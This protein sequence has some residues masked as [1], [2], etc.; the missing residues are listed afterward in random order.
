MVPGKFPDGWPADV[1][2]GD[3]DGEDDKE[4]EVEQEEHG[5]RYAQVG[6]DARPWKGEQELR[7]ARGMRLVRC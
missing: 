2:H 7:A 5:R 1:A 6:D 4:S 3:G